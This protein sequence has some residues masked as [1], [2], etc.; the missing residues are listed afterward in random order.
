MVVGQASAQ[1]NS[2]APKGRLESQEVHIS[3]SLLGKVVNDYLSFTIPLM[4]PAYLRDNIN[5]VIIFDTRKQKEYDVSHIPGAKH[6]G[7]SNLDSTLLTDLKPNTPIVL[8]CS[9][10][11]RSEK[12]GEQLQAM[13][14]NQVYNLY[15]SIFEWANRGYPL[16]DKDEQ[17]TA[18]IHTFNL[19]WRKYVRNK[20]LKRIWW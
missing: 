3:D 7:Y 10:G 14:F 6:L 11:Y 16:V 5:E 17:A 18:E 9:I 8:Y 4:D 15:G 20:S 1:D 12:V 2:S 13:G 19:L